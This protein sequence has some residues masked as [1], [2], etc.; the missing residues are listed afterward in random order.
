M[1]LI[2]DG[3]FSWFYLQK[4]ERVTPSLL[5][6][7]HPAPPFLG[8]QFRTQPCS[9]FGC[10]PNILVSL[11]VKKLA[12]QANRH[13]YMPI[14]HKKGVFPLFSGT[15]CKLLMTLYYVSGWKMVECNTSLLIRA[16]NRQYCSRLSFGLWSFG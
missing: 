14:P 4:K 7:Q 16:L 12:G 9:V 11:E 5:I 3:S 1:V 13:L 8:G 15:S 10:P 6:G 2:V